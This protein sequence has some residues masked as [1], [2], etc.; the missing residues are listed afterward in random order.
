MF[1]ENNVTCGIE[2]ET[3]TVREEV[4]HDLPNRIWHST[5]DASIETDIM[6]SKSFDFSPGKSCK[7][8][9][10][11]RTTIGTEIVSDILNSDDTK[12]YGI[13]DELVNTLRYFGEQS[14]S[15]RSGIHFHIS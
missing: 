7:Y 9:P 1:I 13:I 12:F 6:R 2:F 4:L 5:H 14:E 11:Q 10:C 3:D 15:L 8:L